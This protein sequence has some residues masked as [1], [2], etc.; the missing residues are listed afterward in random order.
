MGDT[1]TLDGPNAQGNYIKSIDT[2]ILVISQYIILQM[3]NKQNT[4]LIS[5]PE[6]IVSKPESGDFSHLNT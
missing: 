2:E 3:D 5:S 4:Q 6:S 1:I